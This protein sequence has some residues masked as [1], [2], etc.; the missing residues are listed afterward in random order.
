MKIVKDSNKEKSNITNEQFK[1]N[2]NALLIRNNK[3]EIIKK[4]IL[5]I[6]QNNFIFAIGVILLVREI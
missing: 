3:R 4:F 5:N 6:L 1:L 2:Q